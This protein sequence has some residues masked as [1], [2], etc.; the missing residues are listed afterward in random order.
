MRVAIIGRTKALLDAAQ[1]VVAAGHVV[2]VVWTCRAEGHYGTTEQDYARFAESVKADFVNEVAISRQS[3]V[4]R[5]RAYRCDAAISVN[6]LTV[7]NQHVLDVF[8]FGVL[9]A[10]AGDLPRYRGNACPNWA[11]LAGEAFVGLCIH[12]MAVELDAGPVLIREKF[13]LEPTTYISDIVHWMDS[14]IPVLF[15]QALTMIE[16]GTAKF[17]AQ[18]TDPGLALRCYPRRP[19]DSRIDWNWPVDRV[20]RMIRASSHPYAGAFTF[21]EKET[22][23]IIWRA[24]VEDV[25]YDFF[26]IPGQVCFVKD[27]HPVIA[28]GD[29]MIAL[30]EV[31]IDGVPDAKARIAKSLRSRLT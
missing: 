25:A 16:S 27:G 19:E 24:E 26:A 8:P 9:N 2:P 22:P 31:T 21:L 28:C 10:H 12:K 20:L 17:E 30:T 15:S 14:R 11:I 5:L 23:V 4:D 29:G 1:A 6:W 13:P 7:L 18:P 3:N